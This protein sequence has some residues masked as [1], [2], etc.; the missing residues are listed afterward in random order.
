M[1]PAVVA[2][3][4]ALL[5][6]AEIGDKTQLMTMSLAS[7]YRAAPVA[8]GVCAAFLVLNLL[9][10]LVGQ[11]LFS[12]VPREAVLVVAGLLFLA[13]AWQS[14]RSSDRAEEGEETTASTR[15]A[16]LGSF[17]LIF[18]A[19]LGDKTQLVL[20]TLAASS[21]A[22]WQHRAHRHPSRRCRTPLPASRRSPPIP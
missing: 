15:G 10:V 11:M 8:I 9:A 13:F 1:D 2:S 16:L 17:A 18:V 22:P 12:Y 14:W 20:L 21:G 7:R 6:L 3:S 5:F 4:F 19:E